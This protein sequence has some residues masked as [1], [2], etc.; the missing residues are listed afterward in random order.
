MSETIYVPNSSAKE[1]ITS[2][3]QI[4]NLS[5]KAEALGAFVKQHKN[6]KGYINL[7]VVPRRETSQHGDT[8]SVKLNNW[9]P[10]QASATA[11]A[12]PT[13]KPSAKPK[14]PDG[15][16]ADDSDDIPF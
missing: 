7:Q 1:V 12:K 8:H 11:T 2:F 16:S 4:I 3:G 6:E 10:D 9:K 5:F 15:P 13:A 14:A